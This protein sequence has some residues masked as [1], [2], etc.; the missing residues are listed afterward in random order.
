MNILEIRD[1][2]GLDNLDGGGSIDRYTVVFDEF[3]YDSVEDED[4]GFEDLKYQACVMCDIPFSHHGYNRY[5][6]IEPGDHLGNLI[7]FLDL[8]KDCQ[9]NVLI[10]MESSGGVASEDYEDWKADKLDDKAT[11]EMVDP[12]NLKAFKMT[13]F[14]LEGKIKMVNEVC[15]PS[16]SWKGA[17]EAV[18]RYGMSVYDNDCWV[19]VS[20]NVRTG[21]NNDV[22][23]YYK[24]IIE[25][26]TEDAETLPLLEMIGGANV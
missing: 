25:L 18:E 20:D 21:Y 12:D 8:P 16:K 13:E 9:D 11:L 1:N 7:G 14:S 23:Y 4:E 3:D 5:D 2:G 6:A 15:I 22:E 17:I 26:L 10:D 24:V 19:E